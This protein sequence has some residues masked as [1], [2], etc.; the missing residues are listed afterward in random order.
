MNELKHENSEIRQSILS[1]K[2]TFPFISACHLYFSFPTSCFFTYFGCFY[3]MFQMLFQ[4]Q[5]IYFAVGSPTI[6]NPGGG[7]GGGLFLNTF[8]EFMLYSDY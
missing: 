5:F 8:C 7:G 6:L 2:F 1:G 4:F 3:I